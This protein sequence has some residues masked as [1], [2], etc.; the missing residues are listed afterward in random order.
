MALT[1]ARWG[2]ITLPLLDWSQVTGQRLEVHD[3]PGL[4]KAAVTF[5]GRAHRVW[6]LQVIFSGPQWK[7]DLELLLGTVSSSVPWDLHL[8]DGTVALAVAEPC[9][10]TISSVGEAR[11][12]LTLHEVYEPPE[13]EKPLDQEALK[14]AV[15]EAKESAL[16]SF[17]EAVKNGY[18]DVVAAMRGVSGLLGEI[19]ATI[20][21]WASPNVILDGLQALQTLEKSLFTL[22]ATPFALVNA[23]ESTFRGLLHPAGL[24]WFMGLFRKHVERALAWEDEQGREVALTFAAFGRE[25]LGDWVLGTVETK[26][27]HYEE[28]AMRLRDVSETLQ[29]YETIV[30][31]W[32]VPRSFLGAV[33]SLQVLD[34]PRL[35]TIEADGVPARVLAQRLYRDASRWWEIVALNNIIHPA[36]CVGTLRVKSS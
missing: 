32:G 17:L 20:V 13:V 18:S 24:D 31:A 27:S 9:E 21:E 36:F 10:Y 30:P 15:E 14:G 6:R 25:P 19:Q 28:A 29:V 7:Q 3:F 34:L 5:Y 16:E 35:Q 26:Y 22:A 1:A 23:W 4:D 11:V 12:T 33:M 2:E 8:P